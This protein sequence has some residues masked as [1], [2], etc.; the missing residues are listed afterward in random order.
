VVAGGNPGEYFVA[1]A[2]ALCDEFLAGFFRLRLCYL[3]LD[4]KQGLL[5]GEDDLGRFLGSYYLHVTS[6]PM[7]S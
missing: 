6:D 4:I 7:Q 2:I 5:E 3:L 1:L